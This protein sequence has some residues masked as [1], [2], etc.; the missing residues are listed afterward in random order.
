MLSRPGSSTERHQTI[1]EAGE[2]GAPLEGLAC[3]HGP[4]D[5]GVEVGDGEALGEE[6][7]LSDD[8]LEGGGGSAAGLA[9]SE[10]GLRRGTGRKDR[11]PH[12]VHAPV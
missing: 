7:M 12:I 3:A 9:I 4:A 2:R 11:P 6:L 10:K 5:D 8:V 1:G